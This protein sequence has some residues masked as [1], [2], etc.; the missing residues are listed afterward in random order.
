M[1]IEGTNEALKQLEEYPIKADKVVRDALR[2]A[3]R[4]IAAQMRSQMPNKSFRKAV[5]VKIA[6]GKVY[7]FANVGILRPKK[8]WDIWNRAYW[9]NYGTLAN[10]DPSH[11]FTMARKRKSAHFKG[12]IKPRHFFEPALAGIESKFKTNLI[13]ELDKRARERKLADD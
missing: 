8:N 3:A 4:P 11:K 1:T 9:K 6:E 10:R 7:S 12:G 13:Q 5:K 2:A